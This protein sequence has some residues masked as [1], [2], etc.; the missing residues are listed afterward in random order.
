MRIALVTSEFVSEPLFDGGLANYLFRLSLSLKNL[1]HE[2]VV[3]V[4]SDHDEIFFY[5]GIEVHRIKIFPE[6][7]PFKNA[8]YFLAK[9][10]RAFK[11]ISTSFILNRN[12]VNI[13]NNCPF[14][15]VQ[16]THLMGLG[17]CRH[18]KIPSVI[19]LSAYTQAW[20]EAYEIKGH[21]QQYFWEKLALNRTDAIFGPS[22]LVN[23]IIERK[24]N[25]KVTLIESPYINDV[26]TLNTKFYDNE[27]KDKKYLLFF[28]T[29]GLLKG[30]GT[31]IKILES[32][33]KEFHDIYFVFVGK[34]Q[35]DQIGTPLVPLI[36]HSA[37]E[38][39]DRVKYLG[40]LKHEELYPIISNSFAV[41]LPSRI[42]NF[43]NACIEAMAHGKI[44]IGT[45]GTSFEQLIIDGKSGFL[46]IVDDEDNLIEI[47]R[48]VIRLTP[49]DRELIENGAIKRIHEL[50]PEITVKKL[51]EFYSWVISNKKN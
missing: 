41:V 18:P 23:K 37:G 27:L 33:L 50:R 30:I 39:K 4:T 44:V 14:D 7:L 2:P 20:M 47:I 26:E 38:Y 45:K 46:S 21:L 31:I 36:F 8:Y 48:M 34:D 29:I 15:I 16:Y 10:Y 19:R 32:I 49:N 11:Y 40:R 3:F 24:F 43:P 6:E 13:H 22:I 17:L 28:G 9:L 1:G 12:L 42:D 51:V 35:G 25:K 5:K